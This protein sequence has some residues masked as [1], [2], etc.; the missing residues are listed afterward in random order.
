M[1]HVSGQ[2][3]V[4]QRCGHQGSHRCLVYILTARKIC[5]RMLNQFTPNFT[6]LSIAHLSNSFPFILSKSFGVS[7][8]ASLR[9]TNFK[10]LLFS[11]FSCLRLKKIII[12]NTLNILEKG[13]CSE[14]V[15]RSYLLVK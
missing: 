10:S 12:S 1:L 3:H 5:F 14:T 15:L 2:Q 6:T 9:N 13:S 11:F 4:N 7:L 8:E